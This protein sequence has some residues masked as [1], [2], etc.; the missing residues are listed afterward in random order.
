MRYH[1]LTAAVI[2]GFGHTSPAAQPPQL[3]ELRT[4]T[5]NGITYFQA[6]FDRPADLSI[7]SVN[8]RAGREG[9]DFVHLPRLVPQDD[10]TQDVECRLSGFIPDR[11]WWDRNRPDGI[12]ADETPAQRS[13]EST[14]LTFYGRTK[15]TGRAKLLL[16]YGRS[17]SGSSAAP[18]PVETP[19]ELDFGQAG[20]T[21]IPRE[22]AKREK[23]HPPVADD[24]EG[25][26]AVAQAERF[27]VLEH[28]SPNF[29]F[30]GFARATFGR[31]Y[32]VFAGSLGGGL[33]APGRRDY[34]HL[35]ELTTGA[36]ALTESLQLDRMLGQRRK[37][38]PRDIDIAKVAGIDIAEHDWKKMMGDKTPDPEPLAKLVPHDNYY[39][40]FKNFGKFIELGD[41]LDQWGTTALRA[42]EVQSTDYRLKERYEKQLCIRTSLLGRTLGPLVIKGLAITGSDPYF[43]EGTDVAVIF[44][45]V[46]RDLFRAGVEPYIR[47]ARQEFAGRLHEGKDEHNGVTIETFTT[48]Q[49]EVSLYRAWFDDFVVYANSPAGIRRV[50]DTRAGKIKPLADSL[51]FRYMRTV[52][53]L[54]DKGEDGFLFLSDPFIRQLVGPASKISE[55]RRLEGLTGLTMATN[56]ALWNAWQTGKPPA[57]L[58]AAL[59]T[60]GLTPA[61]LAC[62]DQPAVTWDAARQLAAGDRY[63]TLHFATPLV[64]LPID[65]V[66][67][68]EE[69]DYSQFR[70]QY[71]GLWRQ[72]FD[73]VGMRF[74]IR[75]GDVGVETFIL[76]LVRSSE[77][78]NLRREVGGGTIAADVSPPTS[79]T[80][81]QLVSHVGPDSEL[82]HTVEAG[83]NLAGVGKGMSWLGDWALIRFD[84]SAT[85]A[86]LMALNDRGG[87]IDNEWIETAFQMP[88]TVGVQI[89][90]P[91][92]FAGVLT[93]LRTTALNALPGAVTWEPMEPD[94]KGVKIVRIR[95]T[96]QGLRQ[97]TGVSNRDAKKEPFL[98]AIYYALI[99]GAWYASLQEQPIKDMID[100][101][102]ARKKQPADAKAEARQINTALYVSPSAAVATKDYIR[103]YLEKEVHQRAL[104]NEPVWYAFQKAG[105]LAGK[106][107]ETARQAVLFHYL[108]YVPVS[109]DGAAYLYDP[110]TDEMT[111]TRHGSLRRPTSKTA[112]DPDS[113]L[114]RLLATTREITADL[115]FREDGVHTT[116]TLRRQKGG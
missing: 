86:K 78:A 84:D 88:V 113:P 41:F 115:Q 109:P 46:N 21:P 56:A 40:H 42:Y 54:G 68:E 75:N 12:P 67:R 91:L 106:E 95:A 114:G 90:N 104:V 22:A 5:V 52:F 17:G 24:L 28:Q 101:S 66:S 14:G 33:G 51:D 61:D 69:Q 94:Y 99:D 108:G 19:I 96:E 98:P 8:R 103:G 71:L 1:L 83:L 107:S 15:G 31:N 80:V 49:R 70:L 3:R 112:L 93:S 100:R 50:L 47:E 36:A 30:Y 58:G 85:Y 39:L 35:Y 65:R 64:E 105:L 81:A 76:P 9:L 57:S 43:R 4:Q 116:V 25:W 79:K 62:P 26:W 13:S 73:P 34:Q 89:R 82:R 6:R 102:E 18:V 29:G 20:T 11:W 60:A 44:H 59:T 55:K 92:V 37:E 27:A 97:Q 72:Y 48:P 45:V 74:R 63:N 111:N 110:R 87:R 77:Y 2:F 23:A 53:K 7:P 10:Q 32:R 38:G 16:L